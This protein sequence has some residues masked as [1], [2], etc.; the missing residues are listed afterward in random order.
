MP[1]E[2]HNIREDIRAKSGFVMLDPPA[3]RPVSPPNIY[4]V[5]LTDFMRH[6]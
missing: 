6:R 3:C 4:E 2:S 1:E 5:T